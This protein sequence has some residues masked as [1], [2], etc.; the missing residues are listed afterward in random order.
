MKEGMGIMR[1]W[2][3]I[4]GLLVFFR[5]PEAADWATGQGSVYGKGT[6]AVSVGMSL[7]HFGGYSTVDVGI[8]DAISVGGGVGYNG[9]SFS[10]FWR[11]NYVPIIARGS[12]HPLNLTVLADKVTVR[13][14]IDPYIGVAAGWN[15]GWSTWKLD[16]QEFGEPTVGGLIFRENIGIRFYP[17]DTFYVYA[18][19]GSGFGIFNFGVGLGF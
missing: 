9:Y 10:R 11:Y 4:V 15:I 7:L 13:N 14:K 17:G 12:F 8:H 5:A 18:E 19:E 1:Q 3:I 16:G 2:L 6:V